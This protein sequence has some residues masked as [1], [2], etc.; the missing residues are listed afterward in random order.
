MQKSLF[1]KVAVITGASDGLGK[2]LS[3][4]LLKQG[5]K[6]VRIGLNADGYSEL[7]NENE[8]N[9]IG[10]LSYSKTRE[11]LIN[12]AIV[13]FG[14]ID[15]LVNN[16]ATGIYAASYET[17][18]DELLKMYDV[19]VFVPNELIRLTLPVF[20]R[21]HS[22]HIVNIGSICGTVTVPWATIYCSTKFAL[23]GITQGLRREVHGLGINIT[24]VMPSVIKTNFRQHVIRG[25]APEN[26]KKMNIAVSTEYIASSIINGIIKKKKNVYSPFF[27]AY[28][29]M[30]MQE[31]APWLMDWY[32]RGKE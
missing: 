14:T 2:T 17:Q 25:E 28:P 27:L 22:G 18:Y 6:V 23:H 21:K 15:I 26:V 19:N 13:K 9:I 4:S 20:S 16:A 29:F 1:G 8:L 5:C 7:N 32:L 3:N 30:K 10:D 31:Y 24:L 11:D 12:R